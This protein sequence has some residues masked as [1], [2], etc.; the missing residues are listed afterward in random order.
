MQE[1][2]KNKQIGPQIGEPTDD[3]INETIEELKV[4]YEIFTPREDAAK[5]WKLK[6]ELGWWMSVEMDS[7]EP[8]AITEDMAKDVRDTIRKNKGENITLDEAY[9]QA[10]KALSYTIPLEKDRIAKE[11]RK[12][13]KKYKRD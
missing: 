4:K 6:K 2:N 3:E 10:K 8:E 7:E 5:Y 9:R 1:S 13:I 12:I 11:M